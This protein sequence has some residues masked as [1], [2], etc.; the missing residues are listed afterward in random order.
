MKEIVTLTQF[1]GETMEERMRWRNNPAIV[2][3]YYN[4]DQLPSNI[5]VHLK[6]NEA[7]VVIE[8]GT[9]V[10]VT[11][12]SRL[13]VN[14]DMSLLS[15]LLSKKEPFRAFLFA[16]TGPHELLIQLKGTWA[17]GSK[18]VGMAGL[19]I[20]LNPDNM[21][22]LLA[23]PAK[24][25][26]SITLGDIADLVSLEISNKF[27]SMHVVSSLQDDVKNNPDNM[28]L[29]E[30]GLR[31]IAQSA[32]AD[33]GANLE[34]VWLS[35]NPNEHDRIMAMRNELELMAE[36]GRLISEK[37]RLEMERMLAQEVSV[38]ERQHQLLVATTEYEAKAA[39]AKDLAA[40]RVKAER[41]REQWSVI[42]QRDELEAE[43]KRRT[44]ELEARQTDLEG[45]LEHDNQMRGLDRTMD[46]EDKEAELEHR[47]R[48]R[49]MKT[50]NEQAEFM[51]QQEMQAAKHNEKML[52]GVFN[53]MDDE[54]GE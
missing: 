1:E 11:K 26:T 51:R 22:R 31:G 36:E 12:S 52:K 14:P 32:L 27:N 8:N 23:L 18:A 41:E 5:D 28:I 38:L 19:K 47:R 4:G 24:G 17:D 43:N 48:M 35:W 34:R 40:L 42:T 45:S 30:S 53:A 46:F 21:G 54:D 15:K 49:K 6:P 25:K 2:A 33:L 7:C 50:A 39:A 16:H 10:S 13:T 29:M 9:I 20:N 3:Q 44:T 37:N